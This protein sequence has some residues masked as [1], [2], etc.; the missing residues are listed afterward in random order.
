VSSATSGPWVLALVLGAVVISL[1]AFLLHR[2]V[3]QVERIGDTLQG[4]WTA[5]T[6]VAGNTAATWLLDET[7]D[8]LDAL[9]E[10]ADAH[11]RMFRREGA[12]S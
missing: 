2:F 6:N 7:T 1:T 3:R 11:G 9:L 12:P 8:R 4:V 10:E 5:G